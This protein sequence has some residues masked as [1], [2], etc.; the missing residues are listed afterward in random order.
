MRFRKA[1]L[2]VVTLFSAGSIGL[3]A[4]HQDG[5][6]WHFDEHDFETPMAQVFS[7]TLAGGSRIGVNVREVTADDVR[8]L[9]LPSESGALITDVADDTPA[10]EAGLRENDVIVEFDGERVRSAQHLTRLVRETPSGRSVTAAVIRGGT[11]TTV[12][13][14]PS[15][16]G[17]SMYSLMP[18]PPRPPRAPR[19]PSAPRAPRPP[20]PPTPPSIEWFSGDGR[21][22]VFSTGGRL[23]VGIQSLSDQ[24][25][26]YFGVEDG[27]LVTSVE[28]DS[29]AEKAGLR[30]GDVITKV[31]D[32]EIDDTGDLMR[33]ISDAEGSVTIQIVRD[34]K[35]Q[36][37]TAT[38]EEARRRTVRRV[39]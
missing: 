4:G 39:I 28:K 31:G 11:R 10:D 8:E 25:A 29:A 16:S 13:V 21:G 24:L 22:F 34:K 5:Q 36:T 35:T 2:A 7:A 9:R 32:R 26:S 18:R 17:G 27:V 1:A 19:A 23:G 20:M 33:A 14:K 15:A 12:T 3:A 30:A 37:V 38:L 6:T